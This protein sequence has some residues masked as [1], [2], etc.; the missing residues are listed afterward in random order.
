MFVNKMHEEAQK[1]YSHS[2]HQPQN[3]IV[4]TLEWLQTHHNPYSVHLHLWCIKG[5]H[6]CMKTL[7]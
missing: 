5:R 6:G 4:S 2:L 7:C 3:V 1:F